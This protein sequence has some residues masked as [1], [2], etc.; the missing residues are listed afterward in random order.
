MLK[1]LCL[2]AAAFALTV[3]ASVAPA[4][5]NSCPPP[6]QYSGA[7]IQV[8]VWAENPDTGECCGYYPTPCSAP[9]GWQ[10]YNNPSCEDWT[11]EGL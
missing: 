3:A 9:A 11:I 7:C 5:S 8:I 10:Q 1:K 2:V 6:R 4:S